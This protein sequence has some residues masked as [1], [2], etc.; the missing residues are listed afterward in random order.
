MLGIFL[1]MVAFLYNYTLA[2]TPAQISEVTAAGDA[3]DDPF[4]QMQI[5]GEHLLQTVSKHIYVENPEIWQAVRMDEYRY[6][7]WHI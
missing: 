6:R 5:A 1:G 3:N 7:I 4:Q 2:S